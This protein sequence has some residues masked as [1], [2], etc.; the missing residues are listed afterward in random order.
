MHP[1]GKQVMATPTRGPGCRGKGW[2]HSMFSCHELVVRVP[3]R[4]ADYSQRS[5]HGIKESV[6]ENLPV[7]DA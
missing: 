4:L 7:A 1:C 5:E 3:R 6:K 2:R